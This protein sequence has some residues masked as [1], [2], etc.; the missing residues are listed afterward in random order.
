MNFSA[1]T[2]GSKAKIAIYFYSFTGTS[3]SI[4][5]ALG[6]TLE[7][8]PRRIIGPDFNYLLWLILS[9]IPNLGVRIH[10]EKPTERYGIFIFPKWTFNCPPATA[11]LKEIS[12]EKLLLV[13]VYG[14]WR[15][16]PYGEY[17]K[18]LASGNSEKVELHFI[19]RRNW[20]ENQAKELQSLIN[21][22]RSFFSEEALR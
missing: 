12:L 2:Q 1:T 20:R 18:A 3:G 16:K 13:I 9:F 15:E 5:K 6:E 21:R 8:Q 22:V 7:I 17:Y 19:R 11:F 10:Y 4:A 14:G